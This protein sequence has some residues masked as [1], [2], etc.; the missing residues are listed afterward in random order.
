MLSTL[1]KRS[2]FL[3]KCDL[4]SKHLACSEYTQMGRS[5][6]CGLLDDAVPHLVWQQH[7]FFYKVLL[8]SLIS[9]CPDHITYCLIEC[10][11]LETQRKCSI[12]AFSH[13]ELAKI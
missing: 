13:I 2:T 8:N 12:V 6:L 7:I 3:Y 5:H 1:V 4:D 11:H 9:L 10:V